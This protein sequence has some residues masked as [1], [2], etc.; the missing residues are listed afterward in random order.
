MRTEVAEKTPSNPRGAGR[1][2]RANKPTTTGITI[3]LTA[4]ERTR[5]GAAA[6]S[7]GLTLGEWLRAAA[8]VMLKAGRKGRKS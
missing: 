5:F 8:E 1:Y 2:P 7:A 6:E 4:D 3:R